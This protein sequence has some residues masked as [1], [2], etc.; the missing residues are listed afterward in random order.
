MTN[1]ARTIVPSSFPSAP[2]RQLGAEEALARIHHFVEDWRMRT[3]D[4]PG[5]FADFE[6]DL[7]TKVME[8]EREVIAADM[9]RADVDVEAV[10]V[11]GATYR[12]VVRCEDTYV[13]AAGPVRIERTLYKD[14]TD[15]SGR[16]L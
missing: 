7:H 16:A 15:E 3:R 1:T 10:V 5:S 9:A 14:R 12:R 2:Q 8:F 6:R 4:K 11:E 13:T